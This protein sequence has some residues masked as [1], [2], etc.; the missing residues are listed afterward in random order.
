[1][2]CW[3]STGKKRRAEQRSRQEKRRKEKRRDEKRINYVQFNSHGVRTVS[4]GVDGACQC[5]SGLLTPRYADA[6]LP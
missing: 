3:E 4:I 1:M 2:S 6:P 5:Y